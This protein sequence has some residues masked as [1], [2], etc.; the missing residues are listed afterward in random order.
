MAAG[1]APTAT[2]HARVAGV[3]LVT[4]LVVL[5]AA[6]LTF[7][8]QQWAVARTQSHQ[9]YAGLAQVTAMTEAPAIAR[10]DRPYIE[11]SLQAL[12]GGRSL[13]SARLVDDKGALLGAYQRPATKTPAKGA[14]TGPL[15]TITAD[16]VADGRKVGKLTF[17]VHSPRLTALLPQF[18]ALTF[19]LLFGGIGVALFLARGMA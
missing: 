1:P 3:G 6:C 18:L 11:A 10:G 4:T 15:E 2:F 5:V 19:A 8:L 16:V 13:E 17:Q 7:M 12:A 9:M 14:A